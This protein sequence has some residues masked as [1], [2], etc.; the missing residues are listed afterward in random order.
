MSSSDLSVIILS[1]N[2]KDITDECLSR[3]QV[4]VDR[5][6]R[7]LGN[8]IEVI[9]LDNA[10]KDGSA[11]MIENKHKWVRLIKSKVNTGY[12]KGNN[13]AFKK[14][15]FPYIL[16][17]NSDVFLEEDSL[18][19]SLEYFRD[20]PDFDV[21]GPKLVYGNGKFQPSAGNLPTPANTIFWI[22]GISLIPYIRELTSPFHPNYPNFF[23][24]VKQVGWVTGAFFA[25]K[26]DVYK[27][28]GG[29]DESIFMYMDEVDFCKRI[30]NLG[31]KIWYVPDISVVHLHGTSSKKDPSFPII[32]ELK[33]LKV[34]F[35]KYY[36]AAYPLVKLFMV[37]GLILR[38]LAFSLL[39]KTKRARA[40]VEGLG[41]I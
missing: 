35:K 9:V 37:L 27:K 14:T 6:Q 25:L 30:K 41:V 19:K 8:K 26:K 17:L 11:E 39:G 4:A 24:S 34:Y 21:L 3:L 33:G 10:S 16:L 28:V 1:Y 12:S 40:Y 13:I 36:P 32:S 29:F 2:T 23:K 7:K 20:H 22:L 15:S 38:T 5:C 18:T 31:Y